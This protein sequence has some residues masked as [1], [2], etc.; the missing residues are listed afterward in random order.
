[1]S[2]TGR[3][4]IK[5]DSQR[6]FLFSQGEISYFG[7]LGNG[8][9][10]YAKAMN[11]RGQIAGQSIQRDNGWGVFLWQGGEITELKTLGGPRASA[12]AIND[13]GTVVGWANPAGAAWDQAH[14]VVWEKGELLDLN[15]A[16]W[17]TSRATSINHAGEIVGYATTTN[18]RSFAFLKRGNEILD[19]NDLVGTNSGW[20]LYSANEINDRGQILASGK[21]GGQHRTFLVSP[22]SLP[23]ASPVK[24]AIAVVPIH[25]STVVA[26]Q[27]NLRSFERLPN[28]AFR[29]AFTGQP[30]VGYAIEAST[31]LTTWTVLGEAKNNNGQ[32]EFID[33]DAAKFSLRFYRAVRAP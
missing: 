21:Q 33:L 12:T 18:N 23:P 14:A 22:S 25:H 7:L 5:D 10:C 4:M 30:E 29:L 32:V 6:S 1:M 16:G 24:S 9:I 8:T 11:N 19:L 31:N 20:H 15:A 3:L 28:G 13:Q 26:S 17:K 2:F 27:F